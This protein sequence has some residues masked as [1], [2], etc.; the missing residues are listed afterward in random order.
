MDEATLAV[1][2]DR[3]VSHWRRVRAGI[4]QAERMMAGVRVVEMPDISRETGDAPAQPRS[5]PR[6]R[7]EG[8]GVAEW[9]TARGVGAWIVPVQDVQP[10]VLDRVRAAGVAV[11]DVG[12]TLELPGVAAVRPDGRAI[13]RL[14]A[15]HLLGLGHRRFAYASWA[16][17]VYSERRR[18]GFERRLGEERAGCE[19]FDDDVERGGQEVQRRFRRWLTGLAEAGGPVGLLTA[20]DVMAE[21]A[22]G[23]LTELGIAVPERVAVVGVNNDDLVVQLCDP[24]LTSVDPDTERVGVE[25]VRLAVRLM[26]DDSTTTRTVLVPPRGVVPRGSTGALAVEDDMVRRVLGRLRATACDG[27]TVGELLDDLPLSRRAIELRFRDSVGRSIGQ[28]RQRL[29][30]ERARHL[31][32]ETDM[33]VGTIALECGYSSHQRLTDAF[34]KAFDESPSAYRSRHRIT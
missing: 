21:R 17:R 18:E 7:R 25:A 31:L 15:E 9:L 6:R 27:G 23:H 8:E 19:L 33:P 32:I 29:R 30:F 24:P 11:V 12:D 2:L 5:G 14:A 4:A 16:G 20:T 13:G 10:G 1:R 26:A 28:E 34:S 3:R 22:L